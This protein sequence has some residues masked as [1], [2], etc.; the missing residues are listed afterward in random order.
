MGANF[1]VFESVLDNSDLLFV[2]HE[3]HHRQ[4]AE[5]FLSLIKMIGSEC[6]DEIAVIYSRIRELQRLERGGP[7]ASS[8]NISGAVKLMTIHKSKGLESKVVI[9]SGLYSAGSQDASMTGG[10][11]F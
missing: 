6:G 9:V 1:E 5:A 2:Y 7:K 4:H 3:P 11:Q 10:P 8:S